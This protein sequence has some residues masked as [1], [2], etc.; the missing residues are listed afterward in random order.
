M[1]T[2]GHPQ[3]RDGIGRRLA[4]AERAFGIPYGAAGS[5]RVMTTCVA[6]GRA[7]GIAASEVS[8]TGL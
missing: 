1:I 5:Y 3:Q 2:D 6:M 4:R 7:A 8:I